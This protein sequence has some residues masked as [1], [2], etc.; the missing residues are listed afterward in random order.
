MTPKWHLIRP[1]LYKTVVDGVVMFAR[2]T[3]P[4]RPKRRRNG[5]FA[6]TNFPWH[7][8]V[9][10]RMLAGRTRRLSGA[11]LKCQTILDRRRSGVL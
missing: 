2:K 1:G 4:P 6:L 3:R 8:Y 9:G 7:C 10:N 5:Q 11:M